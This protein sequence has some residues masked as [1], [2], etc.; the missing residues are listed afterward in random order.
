MNPKP[1]ALP[2]PH[3]VE[4]AV[5]AV[6]AA[7]GHPDRQ[8]Q[9]MLRRRETLAL[10]LGLVD[11]EIERVAFESICGQQDDTQDVE[12]YDGS[13][14]VTRTFVDQHE[15][16]VGQLQ[17]L[18]DLPQRFSGPNDSPGDVAGVRWGSGGLF[19]DDLF[20]TAGHCFDQ[21]GGGWQRPRR[22]G[23]T[24]EPIEIAILMRVNFNYQI[25]GATGQKRP[26]EPFPVEQ[27]LEYRLGNL[28]FAIVR[29]GRN[30]AGRLPGEVYGTLQLAPQNL[31]NVGAMLCLIQHPSGRP[32]RIEAGPMRHNQAAQIAYDSLDTEGGSSG[33]PI[34]STTGEIV[35]VH[36]NGGCAAFSGFNF[37]VPIGSLRTA[38]SIIN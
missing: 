20:I 27:L 1:V 21:H 18:D 24:I 17:W 11:A 7:V 30:S 25:N 14:G 29:L 4:A 12:L 37:G 8:L 9:D 34:L 22:N 19:A 3:R 31:T 15:P 16:P 33:S 2:R 5:A 10:E 32:K 28:D 23:V 26:G 35:G 13:L 6:L 36:T 38:S